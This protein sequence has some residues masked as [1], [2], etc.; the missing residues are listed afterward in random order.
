MKFNDEIYLPLFS[1]TNIH[2][3][4][5]NESEN[6][7]IMQY[8]LLETQGDRRTDRRTTLIPIGGSEKEP[9]NLHL[10]FRQFHD[11]TLT[12]LQITFLHL[13]PQ[14]IIFFLEEGG[15]WKMCGGGGGGGVKD[16]S[17]TCTQQQTRVLPRAGRL[18]WS[19]QRNLLRLTRSGFASF[20]LLLLLNMFGSAHVSLGPAVTARAL[21]CGPDSWRFEV[22]LQSLS[23]YPLK[24]IRVETFFSPSSLF[25]LQT[26]QRLYPAEFL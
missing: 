1:A 12:S 13:L 8:N 5:S 21:C 17:C 16:P 14:I 9:P 22:L 2:F 19:L 15:F 7:I 18:C 26:E 6:V 25:P 4:F 11:L 20:L 24:G 23:I 3:F 10:R